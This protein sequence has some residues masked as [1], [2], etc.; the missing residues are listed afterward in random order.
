MIPDRAGTIKRPRQVGINHIL[1]ILNTSIQNPRG[2]RLARI[3]NKDI[4]PAKVGNDVLDQPL[5]VGVV[6]DVALVRLA[7]DAVPA[8]QLLRVLVPA[9]RPGRVGD[10][11]VGAH[12]GAAARRFGADAC[13]AGGARHHDHFAFEA[14]AGEGV[15]LERAAGGLTF[16][17]EGGWVTLP[18]EVFEL[19]GLRDWSHDGD[20]VCF[21][22]GSLN[23][24]KSGTD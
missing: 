8:R 23:R 3:R 24:S 9:V 2:R 18:E 10:G 17:G 16:L 15:S 12:F 1:P 6:G 11:D 4:N 7:A 14:A 22:L 20:V 5:D 13:R 19:G 21:W